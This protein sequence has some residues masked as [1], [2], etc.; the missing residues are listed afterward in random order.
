MSRRNIFN[1]IEAKDTYKNKWIKNKILFKNIAIFSGIFLLALLNGYNVFS[2]TLIGLVS[3]GLLYGAKAI[4]QG[5][6]KKQ[7]LCDLLNVSECLRVQISAQIP[8]G[9]ALRNLPEL[10]TNKEF[11]GLIKNIYLEYELS[12]FIILDSGQA[13]QRRFNYPEIRIFISS[14][15]QQIQGASAIEAFDNL[16]SILKEKYI[17]FFEESTKSKMAITLKPCSTASQRLPSRLRKAA[18][19]AVSGGMHPRRRPA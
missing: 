11:A 6:Y 13:L 7:V 1:E 16:I 17:E 4:K 5:F 12:K 19:S 2:S 18:S 9:K 3:I 10:C 14:L 15:N 8:L